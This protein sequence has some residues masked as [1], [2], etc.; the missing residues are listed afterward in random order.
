MNFEVGDILKHWSCNGNIY[1]V[2][3]ENTT[4][5]KFM[6][7]FLNVDLHDDMSTRKCSVF[8]N[9]ITKQFF[10]TQ[11]DAVENGYVKL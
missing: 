11:E 3:E 7:Q 10:W 6:K 4:I 8:Y 5:G 1:V 2:V 9:L